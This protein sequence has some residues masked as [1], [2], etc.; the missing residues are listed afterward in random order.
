MENNEEVTPLAF[1]EEAQ[2]AGG[3][4]ISF[5]G[6]DPVLGSLGELIGLLSSSGDDTYELVNDWFTDPITKTKSGIVNNPEQF[7]AL[8][9][10]VLGEVG[11]NA[12]GI[13]V[14][15]PALLGTWYPIMNG[16]EPTGLYLVAYRKDVGAAKPETVLG[17]GTMHQWDVPPTGTAI[18]KVSAWGLIPFIRMGNGALNMTFGTEG[19]PIVTGIAAEGAG[20]EPLVDING[21]SFDG[22]KVTANI[23]LAS[24]D[25]F[26]IGMEVL[27]LL[28]PGDSKPSNRSLADL[29]AITGEQILETASN[30]FIGA[31]SQAFPDQKTKITYL[32]PMLGLS[33]TVPGS[34]VKMPI[35]KWYELFQIAAD[36]VKYPQG[37]KEPFLNWFN[38]L[39]TDPALLK[40]WL[41]CLGSFISS[42][43]VAVT[44]TGTRQEPFQVPL[45]TL[46]SF[47]TLGFSTGTSTVENGTRF[48]YPGISYNGDALALGTSDAVFNIQAL[49]ELAQFRLSGTGPAV[50]PTIDFTFRFV[51]QN[52]TAGT[53][54]MAWDDY[55]VGNLQGG[56]NLNI[57]GEVMPYFFL[58]DVVTGGSSFQSLNLLSPTELANAG[59]TALSE[60]LQ[61]LLGIKDNPGS[62]TSNLAALIGLIAPGSAGSNWP[63]SLTAPFSATGMVNSISDPLHAWMEY[64]LNTLNYTQDVG[65]KKA[66]TYLV[67][68]FALL[69][70]NFSSSTVTIDVTGSGS[71]SD[72]W[73]ASIS[74]KET[75]LP[76]FLTAW[77]ETTASGN[78]RLV[79]G[80]S[81]APTITVGGTDI[82]PS[83]NVEAVSLTFPKTSNESTQATWFP[84]V[85]AQLTL[86]NGYTTPA[87]G[88]VT[89]SVDKSQLSA[90]WNRSNG[91]AWSMFVNQP[92][93]TVNGTEYAIGEDLNFSEIEDLKKLVTTNEGAKVFG[94]F[95]VTGL[96]VALIR[97]ETRAGL[98]T[99]GFM[100]LV[101]DIT[102]AP[103]YPSGLTW[104]GFEQYKI[105]SFTDPWTDL[106]NHIA[107][108]FDTPEK[109]KSALALLS[110]SVD[111]DL[112]AA[113]AI[114]GSGTYTDPWRAPMPGGF[115]LPVWYTD[116]SKVIGTGIS[117]S[118]GFNYPGGS[119]GAAVLF[120]FLLDSRLNMVEYDLDKGDWAADSNAPSFNFIGT[121]SRP[122][123]PDGLLVKLP[124][125]LGSVE[126][127]QVGFTLTVNNGS[128]GFTPV[129]N[130]INVT[131]SGQA[132]QDLITLSD[133]QDPDF[134]AKLQ[135]SFL[136]ILNAGLQYAFDQVKGSTSFQ[137][138]YELLSI[139]GL[140]LVRKNNDDPYGINAAG[141]NALLANPDTY[142]KQQLL[143]MLAVPAQR[144]QLF[145][146]LQS[147]FHVTFPTFPKPLLDVLEA[148]QIVG[149][150]SQGYPLEPTALLQL[151]SSPVEDMKA[152]F[153]HLFSE[154]GKEA[155]AT[156]T[157]ELTKNIDQKKYGNFTFGSTSAGVISLSVLP[158]DAF[159]VGSFLNI[160]GA[161]QLD[162]PNKQ[163]KTSVNG[164]VPKV[165]LSLDNSLD[166]SLNTGSLVATPT[167]QLVW[168]DGAK[169]NAAPLQLYPFNGN[170]FMNS[171]ADLA[172][173]YSLNI[174]LNAVMEEEL[175]AKY[176]LVQKI[177]TGLGLGKDENGT[178]RMPS[179]M[180]I[181]RD[182]MGWLLS[183]EV[184]GQ[185]GKFNVGALVSL[186]SNL[187]DVTASNGIALKPNAKGMDISGLPYGFTVGMAGENGVATFTFGNSNI[188]IANGIGKLDE[189]SFSV[190]LDANYQPAFSGGLTLSTG[191]SIPVAFF[192]KVGYDKEFSLLISQGTASTPS[193]LALQLLPFQGWG[194]LAGQ[195]AA[196]AAVTVINQV[197]P[198]LL[199][200]LSDAGASDFVTRMQTF[201]T[202]VKIGDLVTALEGVLSNITSKTKDE[203]L[204]ELE[205]AAFTWVKARFAD[206][207]AAAGTANAMKTLLDGV[208]P[209][210][211]STEGGRLVFAPSDKIPVKIKAGLNS[212]NLVGLWTDLELPSTSLLTIDIGETGV[213]VDLGTGD[214]TFSFGTHL[215]VPVDGTNGPG[216]SLE[217]TAQNGF[218]L[219]FDPLADGAKPGTHSNLSRELLPDFFPKQNGQSDDLGDRVTAWLLDVMKYVLPRYVSALVLNQ[220]SVKGWLDAPILTDNDKS[221]TPAFILKATSLILEDSET[222]RYYLNSIDN[223][224]TM[225]PTA[226]LGNLLKALMEQEL[227]LITFGDKGQ[228]SI[229]IGPKKGQAGYYGLRL[230][231][232]N[233]TLSSLPNLVLQLGDTS[234]GGNDWITNSGGTAGDPGVGFYLPITVNGADVAA[235]F[236]HFEVVLDN[237]GFDF[238]GTNGAPLV[239]QKRFQINKISP[240]VLFSLNINGGSPAVTFG[241]GVSLNDIGLSLAPDQMAPG[242]DNPI[243]SNLLGSGD[244]NSSD[245]PPTNPTFSVDV[246]YV[247][248]LYVDLKSNT[249]NGKEIIIPVQRSFGP[250]FVASLGLGW[251]NTAKILS[252][253][254]SGSVDLAGLKTTLVGLKVGVPVTTPTDFDKYTLDLDGIDI[255]FSGGSVLISAGLLKTTD[256]YL[257][258]TGTA[259]VKAAA[260]SI[261]GVG[262]YAEV[263][264]SD[265]P[266]AKK[267][268]SLF[269][270]GALNAP[271]GGV[272]AFFIT[273]VAAGFSFNR[274][275]K[276]P[277]IDQVQSFPLV[278]GVVEG[279]FTEGEDP[280]DALKKLN[281]VVAPEVGQYWL[282]AGLKFTSFKLINSTAL[283]F[284]SFG[285][286]WEVNLLGL[287]YASLPP[288]VGKD[289]ALAY[290][291]LALKVSF[292]PTEGIISAE[293]QL[294]PNSFVL[295]KECKVTGGFA[296]FLW[297]KDIVT[298]SY[299]IPAGDFVISL[300][301]YHP[302][303]NK[304]A[305]YPEVPRLGLQW[306]MEVP[307]GKVSINGG[308][309]FALC[310]TAVMAGGYLN[311]LFEAGPL[312]AW[313]NAYANFLIEWKPF[314][315]NVGIGITI[316]ASF[317]TT[318][319]GVSVTLSA[320]L[321]AKL[322]LEG[323]PTHGK[324]VVNWYVISF[325]IPI[326]KDE[327]ATT[328]DNL[329]WA[330]FEEAFLPQEYPPKSSSGARA[331]AAETTNE[332][333]QVVKWN[334]ESGLQNADDALW[335]VQP[336][337]FVVSVAS[338]IPVSTL[339]VTNS[340]FQQTGKTVGV[341]P[342]GFTGDLDSPMKVEVLD[343]GNNPVNLKSR[344]ITISIGQNGA[345]SALWSQEKL[346]PNQAPDASTMIIPGALF[347][348]SLDASK[349]VIHGDVVP[350]DISNLE[351]QL[352]NPKKNPLT[353]VPD[354]PAAARFDAS[355]QNTA[356][357]VIK[358]SLVKAEIVTAR[359]AIY[360]A[361]EKSAI[362]APQNPSLDVMAASVALILQS[363]P[364]MAHIGIYQNGGVAEPGTP[365]A[366]SRAMAMTAE[367][368]EP[369]A[370]KQPQLEGMLRRYKARPVAAEPTQLSIGDRARAAARSAAQAVA[371]EI[372]AATNTYG[373]MPGFKNRVRSKWLTTKGIV[374]KSPAARAISASGNKTRTIHDGGVA[375]WKLDDRLTTTLTMSGDLPLVV[376]S[377]DVYSNL[378]AL[379][380]VANRA[381]YTLPEGTAQVA[382][383]GAESELAGAVGW[384]ADS[385]LTKVNTV[386]SLS[387]GCML[388]VQNSQRVKVKINRSHNGLIEADNLLERNTVTSK[389]GIKKQ[390]WLQSAFPVQ[391]RYI[392][393]L[394][395]VD[396]ADEETI[397]ISIDSNKIPNQTGNADWVSTHVF[398]GKTILIYQ[399]KQMEDT[400]YYGIIAR[401]ERSDANII[402]LY[403]LP[404]L[405]GSDP[406]AWNNIALTPGALDF[407][408]TDA[409][410]MQLTLTSKSGSNE[411]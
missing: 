56:M 27:Q 220:S 372:A 139:L 255:T 340:S 10:Q 11:G 384:Q 198:L 322:E 374:K 366:S 30:L 148:L 52:K 169:P 127:I 392:A 383:Q 133:F 206:Q 285:K 170:D 94:P 309:Y 269:V 112:T 156:L 135:S 214:A 289:M 330:G 303:F 218:A 138:A 348:I 375:L 203:I 320:E 358:N 24:S 96:G 386:W 274:S 54:L 293:A 5:S 59:A 338:A 339:T 237:V 244:E 295:A 166:L 20:S 137:T 160:S 341:R 409:K 360:A 393:V 130:M 230:T 286:E 188:D 176:P 147:T 95:L 208:L 388:R 221:P 306:K 100:G 25:P 129:V 337:P 165:G 105:T 402:G 401:S 246:G 120:H 313:L 47:G 34:D 281:E 152:R 19:Y 232:P 387:D 359:N 178:W 61:T 44:G 186:L 209:G 265:Q 258:Y 356:F 181:L 179:L 328:D 310:P 288:E 92:K 141:W 394:A 395:D 132:Q 26:S 41:T 312:N 268:P 207:A 363:F 150:A 43:A 259:T 184:L 369:P 354:Y 192:T 382:V 175:L 128:I 321:G 297:Y 28:L 397:G 37:V 107:G 267:V 91:W 273:G 347:G 202:G 32:A 14:Q 404:E 264:V 234:S 390:G 287:S 124:E 325:T 364:V 317:G 263:P 110:W 370:Y 262:S 33:S 210:Q 329:D 136:S 318:I 301:G 406:D 71:Q 346:D 365:I 319:A 48:F 399:T 87:L 389:G 13:P 161:L 217:Y 77:H 405:P 367:A 194:N 282:A 17:V 183:D 211:L 243:A 238:V 235:D 180:G 3:N 261:M 323:P 362:L 292:K 109:A 240:R 171:L 299:T 380:Y 69:L 291:E 205:T 304:P 42:D 223:L 16:E 247:D 154:D 308:A 290:F 12:I 114:D 368:V 256:P 298:S 216:I 108:N 193:G 280:V 72:P 53:P 62:F 400:T 334:P 68:E 40:A 88:G 113:P 296:F 239:N 350:F 103:I 97:S 196:M 231:A 345:P 2:G 408:A 118:D 257:S 49:L 146:F 6:L 342:M 229:V 227:T 272:P 173:A 153:T 253:I 189:L 331:M 411:Y 80:V 157:A 407:N 82:V 379:E 164:Y 51:L 70:Q 117:R 74:L 373:R 142:M 23:D 162:L 266:G 7:E 29:A 158:A 204:S 403:G 225:T 277:T 396:N 134:Q 90:S 187:P 115:E 45:I 336:L 241:A 284:L 191:S 78:I 167:V 278:K 333:Q 249:G 201:G 104:S 9:A 283:L 353:D 326:G 119:S 125:D 38:T 327:N 215:I 79:F 83:L 145:N 294:T 21:V 50:S 307:V 155:L 276:I 376:Y 236:T 212:A 233:L 151:M 39:S 305:W 260:F 335:K 131:L 271:L 84:S 332:K 185:N 60:G 93:L 377:F 199:Q 64:Y 316:G 31:L 149:P 302:A 177:F 58:N 361:L 385:L 200:K 190:S 98:F 250:L 106:R 352:G 35:L 18:L 85:A 197:T 391:S 144:T 245:N 398:N 122:N 315:F 1:N 351:Y 371:A 126:K 116:S 55:S 159:E 324:V 300:G 228:A 140:V 102:N 343:A 242:S 99:T 8:F 226:F 357:Q 252:F 73:K 163:L 355:I 46:G 57:K 172:P 123:G 22:V 182:P 219:S 410:R 75:S 86:P 89:A 121:L 222:K 251:E 248:K 349:Y 67:Q 111:S 381:T 63:S 101:S 36:P 344:N 254:F 15:D 275:L 168:G 66:F 65:G 76:A 143:D 4:G 213:G 195:A 279:S 311:V 378:L 270:F 81:L 224:L 314:Y 174:V